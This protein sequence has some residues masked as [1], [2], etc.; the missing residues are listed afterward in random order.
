MLN[1]NGGGGQEGFARTAAG[2][3][4][5]YAAGIYR[6]PEIEAGIRFLMNHKPSGGF[7]RPGYFYFYGQYYALQVMWTARGDYWHEWFPAIRQELLSMHRADGSWP[8]PLCQ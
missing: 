8:G 2:V 3:A 5:L 6:G 7:V 1:G 4:A